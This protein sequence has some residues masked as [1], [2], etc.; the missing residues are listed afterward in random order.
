MAPAVARS[1]GPNSGFAQPSQSH[2]FQCPW[3]RVLGQGFEI[4][5]GLQLFYGLSEF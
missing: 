5:A 2:G 3:W 1:S 4:C